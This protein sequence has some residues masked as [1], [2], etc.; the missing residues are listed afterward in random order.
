MSSPK[1]L[2]PINKISAQCIDCNKCVRE[3]AFLQSYGTPGE[4]CDRYLNDQLPEKHRIS[5]SCNLCMLCNTLCP[6]NL[7]IADAFH[8]MRVLGVQ[9]P[10]VSFPQ[11]K[12]LKNYERLGQSSLFRL[13]I[14]PEK[15]ST[16]FF[17]GCSLCTSR[18][19]TTLKTY[20]YLKNIDPSIGIVLNCCA[21]P[22]HDMGLKELFSRR[23]KKLIQRLAN[24]NITQIITA[25]PSCHSTFTRYSPEIDSIMVYEILAE[26][27]PKSQAVKSREVRVQDAC[28]TRYETKLHN[29]VRKLVQISGHSVVPMVHEKEK[30]F[31]CGEGAGAGLIVPEI[32]EK[33]K[34]KRQEEAAGK[35]LI[36]YCAGCSSSFKNVYPNTHLLDLLFAADDVAQ[37]R[38]EQNE[39]IGAYIKRF[40]LKYRLKKETG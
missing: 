33:W 22:S 34:E 19:T 24:N 4:I 28:V 1:Q 13:E 40:L 8:R 27:P 23:F 9:H 2:E 29:A 21:R 25:C 32:T 36:T 38:E 12:P 5:F 7:D 6:L 37:N 16:I 11:H 26:N 17:P 31:C 39:G 3:C 20:S 10:S 30:T 14:I 15:C 18:P 35:Q